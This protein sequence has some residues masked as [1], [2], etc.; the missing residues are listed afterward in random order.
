M[1]FSGFLILK[2]EV[3]LYLGSYG[4]SL[5]ELYILLS[6]SIHQTRK[7]DG[8]WVAVGLYIL[9]LYMIIRVAYLF[10][11]VPLLRLDTVVMFVIVEAFG[12]H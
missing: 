10:A 5:Q 2:T 7:T 9:V 1:F 4:R 8:N 3:A 11:Y 12:L 6:P